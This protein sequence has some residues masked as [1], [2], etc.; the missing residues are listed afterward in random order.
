M[1]PH[2]IAVLKATQKGLQPHVLAIETS[3]WD[4]PDQYPEEFI[5]F[6]RNYPLDRA[7]NGWWARPLFRPKHDPKM[8]QAM[9]HVYLGGQESRTE[10]LTFK[11]AKRVGEDKKAMEVKRVIKL[12]TVGHRDYSV[13][14][15]PH[16][17][18]V[19]KATRKGYNPM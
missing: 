13:C 17:I 12:R 5:A 3:T 8:T 11:L 10:L 9:L 7:A 4:E 19:L 15:W 18:A 1:W 6:K 14:M 16:L 2:P